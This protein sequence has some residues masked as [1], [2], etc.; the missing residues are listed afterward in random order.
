[1]N[2]SASEKTF[3]GKV[4]SVKTLFVNVTAFIFI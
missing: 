4:T 2:T 1:M 3:V